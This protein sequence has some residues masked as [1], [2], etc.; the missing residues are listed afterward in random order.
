VSP[1]M[2]LLTVAATSLLVVGC[3]ESRKPNG[4]L[5]Y[6]SDGAVRA[7][8][9]SAEAKGDTA[10]LTWISTSPGRPPSAW[11]DSMFVAAY[12][13]RD[14]RWVIV[15][16]HLF[17][18]GSDF[19]A[20]GT[21][22]SANFAAR[23]IAF[24]PTSGPDSARLTIAHMGDPSG[25]SRTVVDSLPKG[26]RAQASWAVHV[27]SPADMGELG[28]VYA[29]SDGALWISRWDGGGPSTRLG[30]ERC[31]PIATF[32]ALGLLLIRRS[33]S[34]DSLAEVQLPDRR[35]NAT[36]AF[37]GEHAVGWTYSLDG[38]SI[39]Y[40]RAGGGLGAALSRRYDLWTLERATGRRHL[41]SSGVRMRGGYVTRE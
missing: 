35:V 21:A 39:L 29:G 22:A 28:V 17:V 11:G 23:S 20:Q 10:L 7:R 1:R 8:W 13:D 19:V 3:G 38:S 5:V 36:Y 14:S 2:A 32:P 9:L 41:V 25:G 30:F 24:Y 4:L 34:S 27:P 6:A 16:Q 12:E 15:R 18:A 33:E 26:L 37:N 31:A 40:S